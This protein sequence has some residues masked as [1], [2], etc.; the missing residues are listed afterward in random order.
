MSTLYKCAFEFNRNPLGK[1]EVWI[2]YGK[3]L[4]DFNEGFWINANY[5]LTKGSD[6]LYWIPPSRIRYVAKQNGEK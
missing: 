5:K 2:T 3:R 1:Q 6:A 4:S